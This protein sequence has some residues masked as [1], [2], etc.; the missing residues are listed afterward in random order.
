[1]S[2]AIGILKASVCPSGNGQLRLTFCDDWK[3]T[4]ES[5][6]TVKAVNG[7]PNLIPG[8]KLLRAICDALNSPDSMDTLGNTHLDRDNTINS[9]FYFDVILDRQ[10]KRPGLLL[11]LTGDLSETNQSRL[12]DVSEVTRNLI[13]LALANEHNN[14]SLLGA[15]FSKAVGAI[16]TR[17]SS[18]NISI[19]EHRNSHFSTSLT[20]PSSLT[21]RQLG[22]FQLSE[23]PAR[24]EKMDAEKFTVVNIGYTI[25]GV[26]STVRVPQELQIAVAHAQYTGLK[27]SYSV[28]VFD[29]MEPTLTSVTLPYAVPAFYSVRL[30]DSKK[31]RS[32]GH[33]IQSLSE[34]GGHAANDDFAHDHTTSSAAAPRSH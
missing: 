16:S 25:P 1:M 8:Y 33:R 3:A 6:A 17:L 31:S 26:Q 13:G 30:P 22:K 14:A 9:G 21:R 7:E 5:L 32:Q 2:N 23:N 19:S 24:Q 15:S 10:G 29:N 20:A 18:L 27:V 4:R 28:D 11:A 12:A 34:I